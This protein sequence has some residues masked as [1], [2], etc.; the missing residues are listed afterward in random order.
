[1]A[2]ECKCKKNIEEIC[3]YSSSG[4]LVPEYT[5]VFFEKGK[6]Y[7]F[8][9][10]GD[11]FYVSDDKKYLK[12]MN[13][14][15]DRI[16]G[17][18]KVDFDEYFEYDKAY[19]TKDESICNDVFVGN[20]RNYNRLLDKMVMNDLFEDGLSDIEKMQFKQSERMIWMGNIFYETNNTQKEK[21]VLIKKKK[22]T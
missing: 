20:L 8:Y 19:N 12:D 10:K 15:S 5:M 3:R 13:R 2:R 16:E 9:N 14:F 11:Y 6:I 1:M 17:M 7:Y 4:K 22:S 21:L 18:Y